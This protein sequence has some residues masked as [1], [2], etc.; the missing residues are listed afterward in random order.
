[1]PDD[2]YN[3]GGDGPDPS[4]GA[5]KAEGEDVSKSNDGDKDMQKTSI[6]PKSFFGGE[7]NPG[8]T[9]TVRVT[10]VHEDD[11]ECEYEG[12]ASE[13]PDDSE[14]DEPEPAQPAEGSMASMME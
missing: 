7:V 10:A 6:L 4:V 11:V 12:S 2:Y 14:S 13:K 3:D 8:D 1:M 5:P 9:C